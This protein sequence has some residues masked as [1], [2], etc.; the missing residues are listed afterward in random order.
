VRRVQHNRRARRTEQR[1]SDRNRRVERAARD[2]APEVRNELQGVRL[3]HTRAARRREVRQDEPADKAVDVE[4]GDERPHVL[5]RVHSLRRKRTHHKD[6][7][8]HLAPQTDWVR[9]VVHNQLLAV[10]LEDRI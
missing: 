3:E 1:R 7:G 5:T 2:D 9:L 4:A 6:R 8:V 10:R